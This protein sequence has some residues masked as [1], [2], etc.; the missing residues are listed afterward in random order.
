MAQHPWTFHDHVKTVGIKPAIDGDYVFAT[1]AVSNAALTLYTVP[2]NKILLLCDW[3]FQ[4]YTTANVASTA[5]FLGFTS[6]GGIKF[7]YYYA[8][9]A[10]IINEIDSQ[11]YFISQVYTAGEYFNL[12]SSVAT[13]SML[14]SLHGIL[15]DA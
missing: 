12:Y 13:C 14:G 7:R 1:N 3:T 4:R 15:I 6:V 9:A 5:Y 2:A 10:G 11:N 8:V